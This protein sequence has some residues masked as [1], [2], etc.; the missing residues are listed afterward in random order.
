MLTLTIADAKDIPCP[1]ADNE[2][3]VT[4]TGGAQ[5]V[6]MANGDPTCLT[7]FSSSKMKA[8]HG[9]LTFYLRRTSTEPIVIQVKSSGLRPAVMHLP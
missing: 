8:F 1:D 7:S 9:Q 3:S 6:A 4:V 5:F 2:V